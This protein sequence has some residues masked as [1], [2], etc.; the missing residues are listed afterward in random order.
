MSEF[1]KRRKRQVW[2]EIGQKYLK[3]KALDLKTG[4]ETNASQEE[5]QKTLGIKNKPTDPDPKGAA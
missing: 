2:R 5:L 4:L 1:L 3:R